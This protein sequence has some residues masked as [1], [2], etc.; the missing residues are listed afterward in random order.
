MV[1][2]EV[3][4]PKG[5]DNGNSYDTTFFN[6]KGFVGRV[7]GTPISQYM[8]LPQLV[9][10]GVYIQIGNG[11]L[12]VPGREKQI[13]IFET[14]YVKSGNNWQL[15]TD[16]VSLDQRDQLWAIL[17]G[18]GYNMSQADYRY[19]KLRP[20]VLE[21]TLGK[22]GGSGAQVRDIRVVQSSGDGSIDDAV[23]YGF[24]QVAVFANK[25]GEE[26]KGRYT[27]SFE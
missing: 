26:V 19:K 13:E 18:A 20:V 12:T 7:G 8:P 14:W 5:R 10:G 17:E 2:A 16:S 4:L 9:L 24:R 15:R 22:T 25:T 3:K 21:F 6:V 1:Q 11:K 27:Y 23:V